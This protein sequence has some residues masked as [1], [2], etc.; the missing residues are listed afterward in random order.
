VALQ[1]ALQAAQ[2]E[3]ENMSA[4]QQ[5]VSATIAATSLAPAARVPFLLS[6]AQI[7]NDIINYVTS[8][9]R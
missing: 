8:E 6:P 5:V 2:R 9:V 7:S 3:Q 1:A 4:A